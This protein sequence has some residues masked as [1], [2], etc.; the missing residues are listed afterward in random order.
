MGESLT[1]RRRVE[2][3]ALRSVNFFWGRIFDSKKAPANYVPEASVKRR[4]Q[5]LSGFIGRKEF[6]RRFDAFV[7]KSPDLIGKLLQIRSDL[8]SL[9]DTG[10]P[11]VGVKSVDI[12]KNAK[13]EDRYLGRF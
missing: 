3:E 10:I 13:G 7:V 6:R 2:D 8:R 11:D 12:R 5:A 9:G 1:Q 4:V